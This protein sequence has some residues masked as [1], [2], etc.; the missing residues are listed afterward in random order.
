MDCE[1]SEWDILEDPESLRQVDNITLEYHLW[2]NQKIMI[3]Q[4]IW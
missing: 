4:K 2:A 3:M 1:G